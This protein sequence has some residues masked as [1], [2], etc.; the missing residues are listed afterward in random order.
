MDESSNQTV[1]ELGFLTRFC[2]LLLIG[3]G[4]QAFLIDLIAL[5][6]TGHE[7]AAG[8]AVWMK[9]FLSAVMSLVMT[10]ILRGLR[11]RSWAVRTSSA[12]LGTLRRAAQMC[13]R[14]RHRLV[15]T[16]LAI[17]GIVLPSSACHRVTVLVERHACW[18]ISLRLLFGGVGKERH[19][20]GSQGVRL[21]FRFSSSAATRRVQ[22]VDGRTWIAPHVYW[23]VAPSWPSCRDGE[24]QDSRKAG[25]GMP[26]RGAS[27]F[28]PQDGAETGRSLFLPLRWGQ[29]LVRVG[30]DGGDS[31]GSGLFAN[32]RGLTPLI[33]PRNRRIVESRRRR[34]IGWRCASV[35][36]YASMSSRETDP[37]DRI[38][39]STTRSKS[40][41]Q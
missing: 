22:S 17:H 38:W 28:L 14:P 4:V 6:D 7:Y 36:R 20:Q 26:K 40:R 25:Q 19:S 35:R 12:A 21:G 13:S 2:V 31:K 1:L 8:R 3:I 32:Q 16:A 37:G 33:G 11:W 5:S 39:R 41:R 27:L 10:P 29:C 23:L 34:V 18:T 30:G 9:Y 24:N 15:G